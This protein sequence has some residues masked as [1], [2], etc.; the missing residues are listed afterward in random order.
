MKQIKIESLFE[1]YDTVVNSFPNSEQI[2]EVSGI[3]NRRKELDYGFFPL[4]SGIFTE[5]HKIEYASIDEN[6]IMFL[7]NDFGTITYFKKIYSKDKSEENNR[8]IQNLKTLKP[9]LHK[10]FFTNFFLGLRDDETHKGTT[11]TIKIAPSHDD[12][13]ELCYKFF[14]EQIKT[15]NPKTI[16]CLGKE[17]GHIL[18]ET[19]TSLFEKFNLKRNNITE[20]FSTKDFIVETDDKTLGKRKFILVPHPSYAHINWRKNNIQEKIKQALSETN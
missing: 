2:F 7:G 16:V 17:V 5:N 6:G 18:S 15:I 4:G 13:K 11:N 14:L 1:K 19:H 10:C 8:T 9:D 20:L 3:I 12:F